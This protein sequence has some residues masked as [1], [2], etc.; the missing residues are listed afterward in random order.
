MAVKEENEITV[1]VKGSEKELINRL[2]E[3]GLYEDSVIVI[4][5]DHYGISENH[6]ASMAQYLGLEEITPLDTVQLQR[7]PLIIHVP[8]EEGLT[9]STVSGQI[10]L[11]P[12]LLHLLGLESKEDI[13]FGTDILSEDK[14]DF[15]VLRDGSIITDKYVYTRETLY[16]K[17]TGE[18]MDDLSVIQPYLDKAN[19]ELQYSDKI[20][21][22]DLF[23]FNGTSSTSTE[24]EGN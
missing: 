10:D 1:R 23:R 11:K 17:E 5:G 20:I 19:Q 8:G 15:T 21:Y 14:L 18:V 4:Y 3:E 16:N 7:V 22:G 24:T 13:Q 12:T 9:S 2:K 6:N